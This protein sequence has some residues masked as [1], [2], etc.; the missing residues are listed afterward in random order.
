MGQD[1]IVKG[2]ILVIRV[3]AG[4]GLGL[5]LAVAASGCFTS[6]ELAPMDAAVWQER[7]ARPDQR[8]DYPRAEVPFTNHALGP[9]ATP[10]YSERA[11]VIPSVG[12][13]GQPGNEI[14]AR[15]LRSELGGRRPLVIVLPI[16]ARYTYPSKRV[17]S[18]LQKHSKG[19]V[20]VLDVQGPSFLT[21]W[22]AIVETTDE[23]SFFELFAEGVERERVTVVDIR[24]LVDWAEARPEIDASRVA[25]VGFSRSAIVGGTALTQEPRLAAAVLMMGGAHPHQIV[26][27][28]TGKRM[29]AVR[30]HVAATFGWS[31]G[32]LETHLEPVFAPVDAASY[33]G[34]VD[35]AKVLL[36]EAAK[37]EC[38]PASARQALWKT[39]GRPTTYRMDYRHRWAFLSITPL[40]GN[41]LSRRAWDFLEERLDLTVPAG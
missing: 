25:L 38:I 26:A 41:W 24:R 19:A 10:A 22:G 11:L 34:R 35:P 17:S 29:S 31:A 7:A 16:Y 14:R 2:L 36:F 27:R 21:D 32:E 3:T 30:E 20:H 37:D 40:G 18:F 23:V 39:L 1:G 8:F 9:G 15:Y 12:D 4:A 5:G 6:H 28:C 33:P 13:N